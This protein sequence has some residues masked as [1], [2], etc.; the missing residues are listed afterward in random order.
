[1]CRPIPA[2]PVVAARRA[3]TPTTVVAGATSAATREL[4]AMPLPTVTRS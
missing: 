2:V 4:A 3:G 1:M